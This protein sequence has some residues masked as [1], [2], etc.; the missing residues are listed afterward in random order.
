[1]GSVFISY[2][3]DDSAGYAGRLYDAL[4]ARFG[5]K[6]VFIDIDSIQAGE[7][8]VEVVEK[9]IVSCSVVIVLIGKAW[10]SATDDRG[11]RRLD[12]P[13]DFV[14]LEVASALRQ[15]KEVIPVLVGGARM[16]LPDDLPQP[17]APLAH[18][19]AVEVFDQL[20][21]ESTLHLIHAIEPFV[22]PKPFWW[23][24]LILFTSHPGLWL[25][26]CGLL[27]AL[28]IFGTMLTP[29]PKPYSNTYKSPTL[30]PELLVEDDPDASTVPVK[31]RTPVDIDKLPPVVEASKNVLLPGGST[32]VIGPVKPYV[33]WRANVTIGDAWSVV[34]I[35]ADGTVYL[36]DRER[37]AVDAIRDGKEQWA[38]S[39][40]APLG[41]DSDGRLWL[42]EYSFNSR[43]EGGRV[44]KN[45]LLPIPAALQT[46]RARQQCRY[47]CRDGKV[48]AMDA[49]GKRPW[50]D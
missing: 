29:K 31:V 17:L 8:F 11:V 12:Q 20:F 6:F 14:R 2:R 10:L 9:R 33:L 43:G 37:T 1:M 26:A 16:P 35:A 18:R 27:V 47:D 25:L 36:Y 32:Q 15:N 39:T 7:D 21:R 48:F 38:Y 28:L 23:R 45:T 19:N 22:S 5:R 42:G 41:F 4:S 44:T 40:P 24:W 50:A 13:N 34:G 49:A 3:R 30:T 46:D